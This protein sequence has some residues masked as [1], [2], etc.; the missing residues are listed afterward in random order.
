[1]SVLLRKRWSRLLDLL[2]S[3]FHELQK[4]LIPHLSQLIYRATVRCFGHTG[5]DCL[6]ASL[7]PF[8]ETAKVLPPRR[9]RT[10]KVLHEMLNASLPTG[11]MEEDSWAHDS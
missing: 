4:N 2:H 1:M 10:G 9:D 11:Q 7:W 3:E 6:L 8:R 5:C